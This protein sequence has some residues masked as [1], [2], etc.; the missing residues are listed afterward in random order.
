VGKMDVPVP[1]EPLSEGGHV[2]VDVDH[3]DAH[4]PGLNRA[5]E[6]MR[7][8]GAAV[9]CGSARGSKCPAC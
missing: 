4:G 2:V 1:L 7:V 5:P 8:E 9:Q 6:A 3:G